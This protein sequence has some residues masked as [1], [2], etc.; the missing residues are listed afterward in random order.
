MQMPV[1]SI[2][3]VPNDL[4]IVSHTKSFDMSSSLVLG[5]VLGSIEVRGKNCRNHDMHITPRLPLATKSI[6]NYLQLRDSIDKSRSNHPC[7][8]EMKQRLKS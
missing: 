2:W 7:R 8:K 6:L 3:P 5:L 1:L 4:R